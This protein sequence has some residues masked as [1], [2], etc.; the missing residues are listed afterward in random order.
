MNGSQGQHR[1]ATAV[2]AVLALAALLL[3]VPVAASAATEPQKL[4]SALHKGAKQ[5]GAYSGFYVV[6]LS[7]GQPLYSQSPDTGRLPASVEKLYTTTAALLTFGPQATL[8]TTILGG[9]APNPAGVYAGPLYL[10]GGGDPTFGSARFD[11]MNYQGGATVS[12]LV[13][14]LQHSAHLIALHGAVYGDASL[15]DARPGTS[16]SRYAFDSDIEGSLSALTFNRGVTSTWL[17]PVTHDPG[18]YAAAQLVYALR[19]ARVAVPRGTTTGDRRT[20]A[21][22]KTLATVHSPSMAR[23]IALTNAP[24]DNFFAEM[25]LKDIGARF[26]AGGTSAAGAAVV[27]AQLASHF[28]LTPTLDDGSGLSRNDATTPRQVVTLLASML[29]N[30]TFQASLAVGGETGTLQHEMVGTAAQ[31]ACRGKTGTLRDVANLVGYCQAADGHT[32]AFAFLA[33]ALGNSDLGHKIEAN[34][35]VALAR[36]NG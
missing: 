1:L 29:A 33:N 25:L 7:T 18:R 31:G 32:L 10:R 26:G 28:G 30:A 34:M 4:V 2:V 8:T 36:Y 5:L 21:T 19:A 22:A 6:D 15:F 3:S 27:R 12:R 9:T 11:A 23:L 16:A 13:S 17:A 14:T 35:A 24:S 20:P